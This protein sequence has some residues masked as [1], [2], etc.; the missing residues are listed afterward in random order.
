MREQNQPTSEP[1]SPQKQA[2]SAGQYVKNFGAK[3]DGQINAVRIFFFLGRSC[4]LK[5]IFSMPL[6]FQLKAMNLL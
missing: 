4:F 2:V 6:A 1:L 5:N 3:I